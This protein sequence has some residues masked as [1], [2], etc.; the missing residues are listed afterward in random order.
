MH[1]VGRAC[2]GNPGLRC[3][4]QNSSAGNALAIRGTQC[5]SQ[6]PD[7]AL[8]R[9]KPKPNQQL[10][11]GTGSLNVPCAH[12]KAD[13]RAGRGTNQLGPASVAMEIAQR[14]KEMDV[15]VES[16]GEARE[17]EP[18]GLPT[19]GATRIAVIVLAVVALAGISA[20][21]W[22]RLRH[23]VQRWQPAASHRG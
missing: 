10:I 2:A 13:T 19:E 8:C 20:G 18:I 6:A 12:L 11:R 4:T 3:I 17:A 23:R 7:D 16:G 21:A 22:L 5:V 9:A 1:L 14:R 15:E